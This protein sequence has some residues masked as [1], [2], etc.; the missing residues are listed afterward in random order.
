[1]IIYDNQPDYDD[2]RRASR[3]RFAAANLPVLLG[4]WLLAAWLVWMQ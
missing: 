4:V 2:H 1:M 3:I